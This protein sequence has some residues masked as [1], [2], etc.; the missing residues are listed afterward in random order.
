MKYLIIIVCFLAALSL[1][2][3]F[4]ILP[5]SPPEEKNVVI[6]VNNSSITSSMLE[7][8]EKDRPSY[9]E[10]RLEFLNSVVI[11]QLLLQEAQKQKIDQE[12]EFRDAIKNYYEQSLIKILLERQNGSIDDNVSEEEVDLFLGYFG[13]TITF[14]IAQGTGNQ[15]TPEIDWSAGSTKTER[16]DDLSSTMQPLLAGLQPGSTRAVF[17]TGNE[18][19]A[20]RV[21]NLTGNAPPG[22]TPIPREMAQSILSTYKREQHLNSWINK[23]VSNADISI[24]EDKN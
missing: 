14:T 24:N 9:H 2:T 7:R 3:V 5:S 6:K 20:V 21:E 11:E 18:W 4:I 17:E 16:F 10:N 15:I 23:L 19:F 8:S 12:P 13:K 1:V 22:N